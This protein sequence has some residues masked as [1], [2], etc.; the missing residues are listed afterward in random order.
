MKSSLLDK[1][2]LITGA[3]SGIGSAIAHK[4][5][6]EGARLILWGRRKSELE[7]IQRQIEGALIASCDIAKRTEIRSAYECLDEVNKGIDILINNAGINTNPRSL[8]DVKPED[9]DYTLGVNLTGVYNVT[10]LV[11]P[12]MRSKSRG[13]IINISSVAGLRA[14]S[15]AGAAYSAS[16]HGVIAL[17]NLLN[18]EEMDFGIRACSLCPGEVETPILDRRVE[19]VD[20]ERRALM[21]QPDD[22]A[23]AAIF[24]AKLPERACVPLLVIKP[25]IQKFC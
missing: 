6:Q 18:E 8:S 9:W 1:R 5:A 15:I 20:N 12:S 3:G 4:F 16:K 13:L 11:L 2:V 14:S 23:D 10:R 22:V 7:K 24:V 17:T 21:L 25:V 19:T